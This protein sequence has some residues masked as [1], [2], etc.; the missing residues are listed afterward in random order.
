MAHYSGVAA[1]TFVFR[2]GGVAENNIYTSWAELMRA[3]LVVQ[4]RRQIVFDDSI[5]SPVVIPAGAY[6]MTDVEWVGRTGPGDSFV[7]VEVSVGVTFTG[8]RRFS[9]NLLIDFVGAAAAVSDFVAGDI[10]WMNQYVSIMSSGAAPF[11]A[12]AGVAIQFLTSDGSV[13]D[14]SAVPVL[15]LTAGASVNVFLGDR[16]SIGAGAVSSAVGTTFTATYIGSSAEVG[17][18][19]A[20]LG[21]YLTVNHTRDRDTVTAIALGPAG[22]IAA[23]GDLKRVDPTGGA[24]TVTLPTINRVDAGKK[25]TVKNSS[26][27]PNVITISPAGGQTID[28]A[29]SATIA[30]GRG[31][32]TFRADGGANWE[33][34]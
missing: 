18:Q 25:V 30:V 33:I 17:L 10:V 14:I 9:Q 16:C 3:I 8:L 22:T 1:A 26:A 19:A 32:L 31:A 12:V 24:M 7:A 23:Y 13:L 34:V 27:S 11:F 15:A 29:A 2:P 20:I 4:G 28:A 5:V 21:T 6:D